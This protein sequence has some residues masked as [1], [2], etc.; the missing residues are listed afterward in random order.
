MLQL[1]KKIKDTFRA[2][3]SQHGAARGK[4]ENSKKQGSKYSVIV[5]NWRM[6]RH[7]RRVQF[8]V[9]N[10]VGNIQGNS[11]TILLL[12][13]YK[14]LNSN[15]MLVVSYSFQDFFFLLLKIKEVRAISLCRRTDKRVACRFI[16]SGKSNTYGAHRLSGFFIN[17]LL[18]L[19]TKQGYYGPMNIHNNIPIGYS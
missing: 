14:F 6:R 12:Q 18:Q 8:T 2:S 1:G 19:N 10:D 7:V 3:A 15:I 4:N 5:V 13:S 17:Y 11:F 16:L 9:G